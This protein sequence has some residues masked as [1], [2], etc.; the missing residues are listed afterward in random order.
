MIL[1]WLTPPGMVAAAVFEQG[2][3][4]PVQIPDPAGVVANKVDVK[5]ESVVVPQTAA[6]A[7]SAQR[8]CSLQVDFN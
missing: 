2:K 4:G 8:P 5:S 1:G 6:P 7:G 3:T